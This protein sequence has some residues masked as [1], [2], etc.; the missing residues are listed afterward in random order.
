MGFPGVR[1]PA[2]PS[3]VVAQAS[4]CPQCGGPRA[5]GRRWCSDACKEG[6]RRDRIRRDPALRMREIERWRAWD[7]RSGERTARPQS[8]AAPPFADSLPGALLAIDFRPQLASKIE[9][10]HAYLLHGLVTRLIGEPHEPVHPAWTLLPSDAPS[11]W[12][13]YVW[14]SR[15]VAALAGKSFRGRIARETA[16]CSF[17]AAVSMPAPSDLGRGWRRLRID[18]LT[19]ICSRSEASTEIYTAP[20]AR[21][22]LSSLRDKI[23]LRLVPWLRREDLCL[24]IDDSATEPVST[25]CGP[26]LKTLRGWRGHVVVRCNAPAHW[27]LSVAASGAGLGGRTAYGM[28]CIRISS[29]T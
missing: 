20:T 21:T 17:G 16:R 23:G 4:P 25:W 27:L 22:I 10:R 26:K 14:E 28:G 3:L 1:V 2:D 11:G 18:A 5:R 24:E 15:H 29:G 7:A 19:P 9:L 13:V 6:A 8:K 12:S